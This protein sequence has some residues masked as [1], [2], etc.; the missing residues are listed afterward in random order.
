[1]LVQA[2]LRPLLGW[3]QQQITWMWS[4]MAGRI[5]MLALVWKGFLFEHVELC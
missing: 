5:I 3:E 1:M 2:E 4:E